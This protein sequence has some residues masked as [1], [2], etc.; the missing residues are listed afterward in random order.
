MINHLTPKAEAVLNHS[1]DTASGMGHT[2]I[3]SEHLLI[4]LCEVEDSIAAKLLEAR[5]VRAQAIRTAVKHAT[6]IGN[7]THLSP[8]DMTPRVRKVIEGAGVEAMKAG[9]TKI[10]SEHL[11]LALLNETSSVAVHLLEGLKIPVGELKTDVQNFLSLSG[12]AHMVAAHDKRAENDKKSKLTTL[13][14]FGRD[15]TAL[16]KQEKLDPMIGREEEV[17]RLVQILSRRQKNNPCLIGEPGVGKTAVVEGLAHMIAR[18]DIPTHLK[19]KKIISLDIAGLLAGAKYRGEFEERLKNVLKEVGQ[20]PDCILFIDEIHTIVGAGAAEGA[21]DA[22]NIIK[23]A[24]ARGEMQVIGATTIA[25]Y[26]QYIE[27]DAALERR[28]QPVLVQQ[29]SRTECILILLGLREKYEKHHQI[30][31]SEEAIRSAVDLSIRYL[32]DRFLPDKALDLLDEAASRLRI[33]TQEKPEK[34]LLLEQ[35]IEQINE[36][37]ERAILLQNFEQAAALRD[38]CH[39]YEQQLEQLQKQSQ[40][41]STV[42]DSKILQSKDVANIVMQWTGIPVSELISEESQKLLHLEQELSQRIVGQPEAIT[43]LAQAIRRSRTGLKDPDRPIGSFLFLGS[44]GVGKT[45][46][47]SALAEVLFGTEDALI[48]LDMSEFLEKHSVSRMIGSPPGY[49]G[50]EQGGQ[51][52]EKVRRRP[53]SV[54]LFDEI[55]KAHSDIYNLL[56]QI[57]EDGSLTDS[58]GRRVDFRNTIIILTSNIGSNAGGKSHHLG[59][60]ALSEREAR[61]TADNERR[62]AQLKEAFRPELLNRLDAIITFSPLGKA[63]LVEISKRLLCKCRHRLTDLGINITFEDD[64]AVHLV[65]SIEN[66]EHGARPLRREITNRIENLLASALLEGDLKSGDEAVVEV[67]NGECVCRVTNR[68]HEITEKP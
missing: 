31:I 13:L 20:H 46:L 3:G 30:S 12:G 23:P 19:N 45:E 60:S 14:S 40:S 57:L 68:Q 66:T 47:S 49:V 53:Y 56:L 18:G 33:S 34:W 5:D 63:E 7:S 44:S 10:G 17:Q 21:I 59:F 28:F 22:A 43:T 55:E 58:Q 37:K 65:E 50:F 48:R 41:S 6:G 9:Q 16:A 26:R 38:Q 36:Q 42:S 52:T 39:E 51:L 1:L 8:S 35:K 54:V 4:A 32:P 62:Q 11:L 2:Y 27:K 61:D 64:V 67:E 25:E 29:P 15:L 24:L